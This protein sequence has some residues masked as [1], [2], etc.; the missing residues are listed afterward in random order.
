MTPRTTTIPH[1]PLR[2]LAA[3][4]CTAALIAGGMSGCASLDPK[5]DIGRAAATVQERSGF[6]AAWDQPWSDH[7]E[8]WDGASPLTAEQAVVTAL[9]NNREIR[10]QVEE[11][12]VGRADLVQAGLLPDLGSPIWDTSWLLSEKSLLGKV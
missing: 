5:P 8:V 1:T 3:L 7:F 2:T 6:A 12:A 11:I 9:K 4:A 10:G